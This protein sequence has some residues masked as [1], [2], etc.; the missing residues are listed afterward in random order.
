MAE[1]KSIT[2]DEPYSGVGNAPA[3]IPRPMGFWGRPRPYWLLYFLTEYSYRYAPVTFGSAFMG[4][5]PYGGGYYG[6][7]GG[8][9]RFTSVGYSPY[10]L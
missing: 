4:G 9:D 3:P 8:A 6:P 10:G 7:Y 1:L 2:G 5:G